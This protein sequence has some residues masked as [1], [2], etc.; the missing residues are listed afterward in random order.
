MI[1]MRPLMIFAMLVMI[2]LLVSCSKMPLV[3]I[4]QI[5]VKNQKVN[6]FKVD[7]YNENTCKVEGHQEPSFHLYHHKMHGMFCVS[8][9]DAALIK[10]AWQTE[11]KNRRDERNRKKNR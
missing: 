11:C 7:E 3:T 1:L 4:N 5:D 6:P 10:A 2:S 8:A 9:E